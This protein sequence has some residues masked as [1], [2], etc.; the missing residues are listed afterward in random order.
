MR[1]PTIVSGYY[2][3]PEQTAKAID[4]KGWLHSGDIGVRLPHNGAFKIIDRKKNFFK[5]QQGEYVAAEKIELVYSKSS[6]ISQIF[7]Y[8][9]SF[10][11]YLVAVVVPNEAF[12]RKKWLNANGYDT[13]LPFEETCKIQ[14]LNDDILKDMND[15]AKQDKLSGFEL[16]KKIHLEHQF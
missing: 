13:E 15:K 10:Q 4:E 2:R 1:G 3:N 7:V 8:G 5:L 9:D 11:C 6:F 16:V 14:K 12:I